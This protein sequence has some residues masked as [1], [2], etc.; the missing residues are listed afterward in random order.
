MRLL[1]SLLHHLKTIARQ[2]N[3]AKLIR[4]GVNIEGL[5]LALRMQEMSLMLNK[6]PVIKLISI[7]TFCA[8]YTWMC[9]K[10]KTNTCTWNTN[11]NDTNPLL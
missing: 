7:W 8:T 5:T 1:K 10:Q 2:T 11:I 4:L 9:T 6:G 3:K